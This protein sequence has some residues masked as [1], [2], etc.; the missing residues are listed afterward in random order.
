M[1]IA[2]ES[3][4]TMDGLRAEIARLSALLSN[5]VAT[6]PSAWRL[7]V[8]EERVFRALLAQDVVSTAALVEA[9]ATTIKAARVHIH[10]LRLKLNDHNV[11][12]ETQ[13]GRRGWSL[14]GR[15]QWAA[16]LKPKPEGVQ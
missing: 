10:R 4:E 11:M 13:A 8:A 7:S 14:I 3:V 9:A 12:I 2:A 16:I 6:I 1:Q 5:G 15:E